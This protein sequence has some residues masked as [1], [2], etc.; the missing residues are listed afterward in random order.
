MSGF[1]DPGGKV[2]KGKA[3]GGGGV[4]GGG[5]GCGVGCG[6]GNSR[7]EEG[8]EEEFSREDGGTGC[9]GSSSYY[10]WG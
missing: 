5:A 9:R 10:E 3:G 1:E 2:R 8:K 7:G 6:R 4:C